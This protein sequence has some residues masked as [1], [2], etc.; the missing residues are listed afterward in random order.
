ME[1]S[2]QL[3]AYCDCVEEITDKD[4]LD[5]ISVVSLATG[6]SQIPCETFETAERREVIDLPD[7]LDCP[8]EFEPYYQ[9]Y[10][11]ES[12]VFTLLHVKGMDIEEIPLT[13]VYSE[14]EDKFRVD[15]QLP[16]CSCC[17]CDECGC[18]SEYKLVAT[19]M[20]G[21]DEIPT[22]LLPVFCNLIEVIHTKNSCDCGCVSC[23]EETKYD[24]DGNIAIQEVH[25]KSGDVVSVFLE[26][27]LAKVLVQQYKNQ[28]GLMSLARL[29][30]EVWGYVV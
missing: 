22:C 3:K 6:W 19:Y 18:P 26:T 27:D 13:H 8:Y 24:R 4:V 15:T 11:P 17:R 30:P 28:L 12:M 10:D 14:Y 2:D 16:P 29:D 7:C 21:Y 25:Y 23:N 9:P 20:A 5:M 1:I